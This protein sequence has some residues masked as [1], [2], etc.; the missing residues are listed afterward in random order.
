MPLWSLRFVA[1][2]IGLLPLFP[3]PS[4]H[5]E[6]SEVR[7]ARQLGLGYLQ[8]YVMEDRHLVEKQG[9]KLGLTLSAKYIP[10]G[11]PGPINDALL[12]GAA[13]YGAAG[14]P[15][16][17][18][19]WDKTRSNIKM[20][21][22]VALNAQPAFLNTNKPTIQSLKDFT[23]Q[24]R[25]AVPGVK[26]SLQAI[27]LEMAAERTFGPGQQFKLDPL[28]VTLPH[29]DGAVA[30][31]SGRTEISGH[32]TSPPFQEQELQNRKIHRVLSSY[33]ITNGPA[34]FSALWTTAKF[35][36]DNPKTYRAVLAAAEEATA[37]INTDKPEAARI[38]IMIDHSSL[39]QEF[40]ESMLR[41]K[42]IIY[43]TTPLGVEKFAS[44]MAR[45]GTIHAAPAS[46]KELF[47]PDIYDKPGS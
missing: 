15:P 12:T 39:S 46:W 31:L 26:L 6:V 22:V 40:V 4:I 24:D 27:L 36:S 28:T 14:V 33:E 13:D 42:D 41:D 38:F 37:F 9:R 1:F 7:F 43:S 21:G 3:A 8:L 5:A 25:I 45:I 30:L 23:D 2:F 35:R 20:T 10:L 17:I 19:L 11:G 29:P 16:F 47:F 32:F 44:F 34:S 18:L